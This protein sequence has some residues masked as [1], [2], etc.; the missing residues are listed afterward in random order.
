MISPLEFF[1]W[2]FANTLVYRE[3]VRNVNE[4]RERIDRAVECVINKMPVNTYKE[5]EHH[6]EVCNATNGVHGDLQSTEEPW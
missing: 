4:L 2:G 3:R 1:L 6:F 5:T